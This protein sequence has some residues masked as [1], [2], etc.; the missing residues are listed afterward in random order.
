MG[1]Y[2]E[3]AK[4]FEENC[5]LLNKE[6]CIE[7]QKSCNNQLHPTKLISDVRPNYIYIHLLSITGNIMPYSSVFIYKKKDDSN[8][9][10][11]NYNTVHHIDGGSFTPSDEAKYWKTIH[12]AT[13]LQ[14]WDKVKP[15][16]KE[17]C[18]KYEELKKSFIQSI[19]Y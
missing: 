5:I 8:D 15:V 16:V 3:K 10:L 2:N 4:E 7:L 13:I 17:F 9:I 11:I 6:F 12:A 14:N 1:N 18:N 19:T